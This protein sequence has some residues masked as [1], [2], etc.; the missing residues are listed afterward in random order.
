MSPIAGEIYGNGFDG[1]PGVGVK[2]A[3]K[4]RQFRL[5]TGANFGLFYSGCNFKWLLFLLQHNK[6]KVSAEAI[7]YANLKHKHKEHARV[8]ENKKK[9]SNS[10]H[11][12]S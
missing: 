4:L 5:I 1:R 8:S 3:D 7:N 2:R 12:G 10:A 9:R 6:V 11:V